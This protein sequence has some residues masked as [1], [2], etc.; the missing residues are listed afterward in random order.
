MRKQIMKQISENLY[1]MEATGKVDPT[2]I[3]YLDELRSLIRQIKD[4]WLENKNTDSYYFYQGVRNVELML[5]KMQERFETAQENHDNPK[6]AEDSIVLFKDVD[7]LLQITESNEIN[8]QTVNKILEK[9]RD[10]RNTAFHQNLIEPP[11]TNEENVDKE[12]LSYQFDSVMKN[13][14][15]P[16]DENPFIVDEEESKNNS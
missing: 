5:N 11:E 1:D 13:L 3:K 15:I 7:D 4:K 10:L 16:Q 6:I 14:D 9:T 8:L 2:I 12:L